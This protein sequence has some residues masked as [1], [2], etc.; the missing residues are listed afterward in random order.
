MNIP[1]CH[2]PLTS[3]LNQFTDHLDIVNF[4]KPIQR[5]HWRLY[6]KEGIM[7]R[8]LFSV[9]KHWWYKVKV[10]PFVELNFYRRGIFQFSKKKIRKI[11]ITSSKNNIKY[12]FFIYSSL[13]SFTISFITMPVQYYYA[14]NFRKKYRMSRLFSYFH[15]NLEQG[16][17]KCWRQNDIFSFYYATLP[18]FINW[19]CIKNKIKLIILVDRYAKVKLIHTNVIL[20]NKFL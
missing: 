10:G 6:Y 19:S 20:V 11:I 3:L 5:K 1:H 15:R 2:Q 9:T 12:I 4:L 17:I 18:N 14:K 13:F 8:K 7:T 16:N